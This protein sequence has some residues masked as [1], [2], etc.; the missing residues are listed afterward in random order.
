MFLPLTSLLMIP[1]VVNMIEVTIQTLWLSSDL[2][3]MMI[4]SGL[5]FSKQHLFRKFIFSWHM[6][7]PLAVGTA[8]QV[9]D[10]LLNQA[11][12]NYYIVME[13]AKINMLFEA[14]NDQNKYGI[15]PRAVVNYLYY[16]LVDS[17]SNFLPWPTTVS[18]IY[19]EHKVENVLISDDNRSS[20]RQ[21]PKTTSWTSKTRSS[22]RKKIWNQANRWYF[23]CSIQLC[24]WN[25]WS[26]AICQRSC[27]RWQDLPNCRW[28]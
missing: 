26:N 8:E 6:F 4:S 22:T 13:P 25:Y 14:L 17:L 24:C 3:T 27:L 11:T 10:K 7:L 20:I 15:T 21:D 16:R 2:F 9:L 12:Y 1:L 5:F 28:S 18:E 19:P 23:W